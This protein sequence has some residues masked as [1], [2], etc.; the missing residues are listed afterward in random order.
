M[1]TT[2]AEEVD[3][4]L[5]AAAAASERWAACDT[6]TRM[7]VLEA[8]AQALDDAAEVIVALGCEETHLEPGRLTGELQR[9]SFQLRFLAGVLQEGSWR[10][11]TIDHA[12]PEWPQGVPRPDLRMHLEPIGPVLVFAASNFPLAFSVLGGDTASALAA[13]NA[14]VVKAHRGHP[15]LSLE[16]ARLATEAAR[17]AGAPEGL[18][19]LV[20]GTEAGVRALSAAPVRA[21]A[22]TGSTEGGRALFDIAAARKEPIPFFG[23][24]GS[25]NPVFVTRS[26]A[27]Q[28]APEVAREFI[29]AVAA[30]GGQL[31]TK[32]GVI[33]VPAGSRL[34][35][36]LAGALLPP[37]PSLLSDSIAEGF[38]RSRDQIGGH[39]RVTML[40]GD[41]KSD[42]VASVLFG[43]G[44]DDVLAEPDA[45]MM[46]MFGPASLVVTYEEEGQLL[47][48]AQRV[49]GQLASAVYAQESDAI[50]LPL[51]AALSR[52]AGRVLWN[53]MPTGV[54]VTW[55]QHHGGPYPATTLDNFT[56]VGAASI[57]RFL[58]PVAYQ[59]VPDALLPPALQAANPLQ[60]P[61]RVNGVLESAQSPA[62]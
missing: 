59:N 46:E 53:Q 54:S 5:D 47:E 62:G 58:R 57:T 56:S 61:R 17:A 52:R 29:G 18:L 19:Q 22:F 20:F 3:R 30:S 26:V 38:L 36:E 50:A 45:L 8:I 33:A 34:H 16:V 25:V 40:A 27:E 7:R 1:H 48:L 21:A 32:P 55:A 43:S 41:A 37:S 24:L 23:E 39:P 31:C 42:E 49:E 28:R 12:D 2:S 6:A 4:I 51:L 11:V 15:R 10:S 14:V 44:V 60:V 9:T 35:E 13:G